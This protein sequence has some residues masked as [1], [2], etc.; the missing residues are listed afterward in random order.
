MT[1]ISS[2]STPRG[3]GFLNCYQRTLKL[4]KSCFKREIPIF[5]RKTQYDYEGQKAK[6]AK[7]IMRL[8]NKQ[9]SNIHFLRLLNITNQAKEVNLFNIMLQT[10]FPKDLTERVCRVGKHLLGLTEKV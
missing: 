4:I 8:M 9:I 3:L 1:T 6:H 2:F 5:R 10:S 7:L